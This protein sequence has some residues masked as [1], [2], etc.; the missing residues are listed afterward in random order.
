MHLLP[1]Y[2][3]SDG[4]GDG[5]SSRHGPYAET[6][7][8]PM[9]LVSTAMRYFGVHFHEPL[10]I[11]QVAEVLGTCVARLD[12]CFDQIRGMTPALAL[13]EHRLNQLF[14]RL[15]DQPRQGLGCAIQACGLGQTQGVV[16]LF[17]QEFGIEMPLFMLTCRR[18]ADDRLFRR[19][20]PEP[21][22][23]VLPT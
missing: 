7:I 10:L 20:H 12:F 18:A 8:T 9:E 14:Q 13:R 3:S 22:A 5:S 11:P 17:E 21:Q 19:L 23:L 1:A 4:S 6:S 2:G 16:A 15:S